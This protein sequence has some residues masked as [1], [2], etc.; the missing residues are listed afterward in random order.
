MANKKELGRKFRLMSSINEKY[1]DKL[2]DKLHEELQK[3]L[4][5]K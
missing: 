2:S 1:P 3:V 5:K 4:S